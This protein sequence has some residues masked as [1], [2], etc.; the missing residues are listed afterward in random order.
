MVRSRISP[1][2]ADGSGASSQTT[3]PTATQRAAF[4]NDTP[5]ATMSHSSVKL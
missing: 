5:V 3:R 1:S 2:A 4:I